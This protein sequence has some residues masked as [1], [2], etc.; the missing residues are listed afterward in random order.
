MPSAIAITAP[1]NHPNKAWGP[2]IAPM[3]S[4]SVIKGPVPTILDMLIEVALSSPSRRS[5]WGWDLVACSCEVVE[6]NM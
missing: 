4:G 2:P 3:M 6:S 5:K 1:K